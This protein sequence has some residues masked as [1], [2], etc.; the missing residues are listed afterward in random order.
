VPTGDRPTGALHLRHHVGTLQNRVRLQD[1]G[2]ETSTSRGDAI[3]LEDDEDTTARLI[4][5]ITTDSERHIG[6]DPQLRPE[7]SDLL[8]IASLS[9]GTSP[10]ELAERIGGA[11]SS[12]LKTL[13]TEAVDKRFRPLRR[14]RAELAADPGHLLEV[15]AAGS[16]AATALADATL[17][18]VRTAMQMDHQRT[19]G[20]PPRTPAARPGRRTG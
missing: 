4:R 3:A 12:A 6:Y 7:V 15:L 18:R 14:H 11:G 19:V 13:V 8:T 2:V 20:L 5:R 17:D 10:E 1:V 9:T 16:A